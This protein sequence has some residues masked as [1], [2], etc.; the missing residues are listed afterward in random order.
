MRFP[1]DDDLGT[2]LGL[3]QGDDATDIAPAVLE[4]NFGLFAKE[5][6]R[7]PDLY[8]SRWRDVPG[9]YELDP[10]KRDPTAV[11]GKIDDVGALTILLPMT[12]H[13]F[14]LS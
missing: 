5:I 8:G 6:V 7:C 10:Q 9:R 2:L 1:V 14:A 12:P 11:P 4:Q 3:V 13:V